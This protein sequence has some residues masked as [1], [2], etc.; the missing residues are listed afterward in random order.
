MQKNRKEEAA[1][2]I[3]FNI[4]EIQWTDHPTA[5]GVYIKKII[6]KAEFGDESPTI[7]MVKVPVGSEVPEHV[8][9]G[10]EDILYITS[11]SAT[12]WIEGMGDFQL[13]EGILMRVP[14][15]TKHKIVNV[16]EELIGYDVF[17]P[18]TF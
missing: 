4:N 17:S 3:Q 11:G 16:K 10:Q 14:R 1:M 5:K 18:G 7:M 9:E 8:H 13:R 15:N 6:T 12:M 2:S